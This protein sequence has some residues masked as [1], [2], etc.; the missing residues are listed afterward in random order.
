M[1]IISFKPIGV[2]H[3]P[4]KEP[5]G[6]PIQPDR[7]GGAEGRIE[8]LAEYVRGL[9]DLEGFSHI[10][11]IYYFHLSKGFE[12][13]V[14]PFLDTKLRGLFSTRAPR[15][16][17]P[18]GISV[19]RLKSVEKNILHVRNVDMVDGTP[20]LDIKPYVRDFDSLEDYRIGWLKDNIKH[21]GRDAADDRFN[22][23]GDGEEYKNGT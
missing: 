14:T 20:L 21:K 8:I 15:R 12:L 7:S 4:F 9:A 10:T 22:R 5:R 18:I 16:P 17:N 2:I 19:V 13:L 1:D 6:T 11:L 3:T 23:A